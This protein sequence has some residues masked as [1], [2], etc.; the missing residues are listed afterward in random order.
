MKEQYKFWWKNSAHLSSLAAHLGLAGHLE[1]WPRDRGL[2][3]VD[4]ARISP[5]PTGES[6]I[7]LLPSFFVTQ[8]F[9]QIFTCTVHARYWDYKRKQNREAHA[10]QR[11][12]SE[13]ILRISASVKHCG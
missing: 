1:L 7:H 11:D 8:N 6:G 5:E 3:G 4:L 2:H 10:P 13:A 9:P 12:V